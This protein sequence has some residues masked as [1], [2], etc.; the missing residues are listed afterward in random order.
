MKRSQSWLSNWL[1][2]LS[3]GR[4]EGTTVIQLS[5]NFNKGIGEVNNITAHSKARAEVPSRMLSTSTKTQTLSQLAELEQIELG[6]NW[7]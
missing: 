6:C 2:R 4:L 3:E 5:L 7:Q 1:K